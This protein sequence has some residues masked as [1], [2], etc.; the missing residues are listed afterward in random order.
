MV[1][2]GGIGNL[3]QY[4]FK[5]CVLDSINFFGFVRFNLYDFVVSCGLI[6]IAIGALGD[7]EENIT[8]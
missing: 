7:H 4:Y 5:G 8:N 6:V 2:I 3:T 1:L